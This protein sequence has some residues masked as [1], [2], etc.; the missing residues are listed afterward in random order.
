MRNMKKLRISFD[1]TGEMA[2]K[3]ERL[4]EAY[5]VLRPSISQVAHMLVEQALPQALADQE[6][7]NRAI[8]AMRRQVKPGRSV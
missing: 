6:S 7:A 5:G 1:L 4:I 3:M 8:A 2:E